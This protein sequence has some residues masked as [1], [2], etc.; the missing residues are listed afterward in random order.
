M[1]LSIFKAKSIFFFLIVCFFVKSNPLL[2]QWVP[3]NGPPGGDVYSF[4]SVGA[5]LFAGTYN[6]S[7]GVFLTTNSGSNWILVNS[8]LTNTF[9]N[10]LIISGS[11]LYAGTDG[12]VFRSTNNGLNWTS[13]N[14]G[15]TNLVIHSFAVNG[16]Y[17]FAGTDGGVFRSDNNGL[18]WTQV[19]SGLTNLTVGCFAVSGSNI[20]AGTYGGVFISNN[21]GSN[22]TS[23]NSGLTNSIIRSLAVSSSYL[24]AGTY[25]GVFRTTNNGSN[26]TQVNSGLTNTFV[27]S[28]A[29]S[30][31]NIFA[32]TTTTGGVFLTTNNGSNWAEV[33]TGLPITNRYITSLIVSGTNL[34][35][36]INGN[37]VVWRRPLSEMITSI[38]ITSTE[39]PAGFS[40]SQNYP[41]PFNPSTRIDFSITRKDFVSLKIFNS[42]GKEVTELVKN[43]L[44]PGS[45]SYEFNAASLSTGIYFYTLRTGD[46]TE[47]KK[48]LLVK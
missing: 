11:N 35:A 5:N 33:N 15:L 7:N 8:G 1:K 21:S 22:W 32:G 26:W 14:A 17:L 16:T 41:N 40:L 25:S 10:T 45:Y 38:G 23:V 28:L 47:T 44:A 19:N 48:M 37:G 4:T 18:N 29:V 9:V 46:F 20:F 31:T 27:S 30:G 13:V 36:G 3:T 34:F 6:N 12:G 43:D 39:L 24:F 42:Q 2:A